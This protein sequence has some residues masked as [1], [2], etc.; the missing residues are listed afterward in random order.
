[1]IHLT[2]Y[3]L[4]KRALN[5]L[6]LYGYT[7]N[8]LEADKQLNELYFIRYNIDALVKT[9]SYVID[10]LPSKKIVD[11]YCSN[12]ESFIDSSTTCSSWK[13][14]IKIAVAQCLQS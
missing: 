2:S 14:F 3:K 11:C 8:I 4:C 10:I 7:V 13:D 12:E 1:M 9:N 5:F 6:D